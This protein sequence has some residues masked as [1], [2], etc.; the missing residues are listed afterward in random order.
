MRFPRQSGFTLVEILIVVV[1]LGVLSAIVVPQFARASG[2]AQMVG[3]VDQ[4]VKLR[5]ALAV[6]FV[7]ENSRFPDASAGDGTWGGLLGGRYMRNAPSNIWV[8]G[9]NARVITIGTGPDSSYHQDYGW[10]YNPD[11]GDVWAAGYDA[12]DNPFPKP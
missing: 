1:I 8:G 4:L 12:N 2:D 11:T 9:E 5:R 3:T 7:R 10:I 6:Y